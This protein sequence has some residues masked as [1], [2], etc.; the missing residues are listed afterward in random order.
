MKSFDDMIFNL[1]PLSLEAG[2]KAVEALLLPD[3]EVVAAFVTVRDKMIFTDRRI[4]AVDI[5]GI[6]KKVSY[7]NLP[8]ARITAFCIETADV[9][10]LDSTLEVTLP[11]GAK[12][13]FEFSSGF[14]IR[15]LCRALAAHI[16]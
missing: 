7:C 13:T 1:R 12:A 14:D 3:E 16:L 9:L 6:G 8:Y 5:Q 4:I 11:S 15:G 10:D 2:R